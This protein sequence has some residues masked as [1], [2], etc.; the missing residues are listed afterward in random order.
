MKHRVPSP[1]LR[2]AMIPW[3]LIL[4]LF[5]PLTHGRIPL[6][7]DWLAAHHDPWKTIVSPAIHNP[8]IDDPVLEFYPL[9]D[10]AARMLRSGRIPLWNPAIGCGS[11]LLADFISQPL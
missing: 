3:I 2:A 5:F 11:P 8:D 1:L 7:S 9:A 4:T 10:Q 6:N